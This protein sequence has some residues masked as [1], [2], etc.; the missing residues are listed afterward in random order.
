MYVNEY[1]DSFR[2]KG[3][4]RGVYQ[5]AAYVTYTTPVSHRWPT[6][7]LDSGVGILTAAQKGL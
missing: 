6:Q 5:F 2:Y 4:R 3:K 7:D 1:W